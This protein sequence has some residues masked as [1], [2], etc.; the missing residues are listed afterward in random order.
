MVSQLDT[1]FSVLNCKSCFDFS[2]MFSLR[3]TMIYL[4]AISFSF[5]ITDLIFLIA[6]SSTVCSI[7]C[8]VMRLVSSAVIIRE[9]L[10][11]TS[12]CSLKIGIVNPSYL[13][14]KDSNLRSSSLHMRPPVIAVMNQFR[15]VSSIGINKLLISGIVLMKQL[16]LFLKPL[17]NGEYAAWGWL[18]A[19][20]D[21]SS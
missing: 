3:C 4:Y 9:L 19:T 18:S 10:Y 5:L 14:G 12:A 8:T 2:D 6:S 1:P 13:V 15:M 20:V 11:S 7:C 16:N 17:T 21:M